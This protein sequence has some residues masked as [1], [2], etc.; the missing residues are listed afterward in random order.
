MDVLTPHTEGK[1]KFVL[2]GPRKGKTVLLNKRYQFVNGEFECSAKDAIKLQRILC[3]YYG[4]EMM[5]VR[6]KSEEKP[7][8]NGGSKASNQPS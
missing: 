3:R 8:E 7:A 2:T 5:T 1:I 6:P 4:C